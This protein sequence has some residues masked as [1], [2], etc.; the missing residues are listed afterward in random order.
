MWTPDVYQGAPAPVTGFLATVSKG[1]VFAFVLRYALITDVLAIPV[2]STVLLVF[3]V[4]SM[5]GGNLLA[6]LQNN[7]KRLLAYSSIAH[8]GYLLIA[9]LAVGVLAD[10]LIAVEASIVYLVGYFLMTLAAFGVVTVLSSSSMEVDAESIDAYTGLFWRRPLCAVIMTTALLSLTGIPLT[11]GFVAKFYLIATGAE[12][13]MW[14]LLW[15]LVVGSAIAVYY[16]MRVIFAMVQKG[17]GDSYTHP[18]VKV[19][20]MAV[21]VVIGLSLILFGVYPSPLI[22]FVRSSIGIA[23]G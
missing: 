23:G 6:L 15:A 12:G 21:L 18:S 19:E 10:S 4:L 11:V 9:L 22:D 16:Y 1:A 5:L 13:G 20:G 3:A 2:M 8:I 17:G 7:V 14:L